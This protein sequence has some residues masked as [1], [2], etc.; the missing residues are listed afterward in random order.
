MSRKKN[1]QG[2]QGQ[3]YKPTFTNIL[4]EREEPVCDFL[5][6]YHKFSVHGH[7]SHQAELNCICNH[8]TN[9]ALGIVVVVVK[10]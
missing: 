7:R 10:K 5:N 4:G 3:Q 8:P 6:C 9:A 2:Q 1:N